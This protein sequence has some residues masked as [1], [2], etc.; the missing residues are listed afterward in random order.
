[1]M[2]TFRNI[3]AILLAVFAFSLINTSAQDTASRNTQ[4]ANGIEQQIFKEINGLPRYGVFD[5]I[6]FEVNGGEVVLGGKVASLGTRGAAENVV[7]KIPGVTSVV[8]NIT[9][10]PPSPSDNRIRRSIL[11]SF[12]NSPA[13]GV[14]LREPRPSVRIVVENGH[15]A[16]EGYVNNRSAAD[17]MNILANGVSGVFHVDNNLIVDNDRSS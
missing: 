6:T 11:R 4:P 9:D 7:K 10:L 12:A 13:L 8:N 2:K 5:H 15:V 14:Y 16:L 3:F 17:T 1:M